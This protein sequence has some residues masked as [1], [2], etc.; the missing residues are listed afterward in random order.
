M[1]KVGI[2]MATQE[3]RAKWYSEDEKMA[4]TRVRELEEGRKPRSQERIRKLM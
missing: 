4:K 2:T 3:Y 1:V